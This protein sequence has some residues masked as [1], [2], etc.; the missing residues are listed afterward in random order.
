MN[1]RNRT[2][3][4][5]FECG[6]AVF[7]SYVGPDDEGVSTG[8]KDCVRI[9]TGRY[10]CIWCK[11]IINARKREAKAE[12]KKLDK[13]HWSGIGDLDFGEPAE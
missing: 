4:T 1:Y 12:S 13:E 10:L 8:A 2:V 6:R 5:C 7:K 9:D 11:E 3:N